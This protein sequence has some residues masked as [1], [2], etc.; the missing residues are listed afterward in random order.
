MAKRELKIERE[1]EREREM[2]VNL[3]TG[4]RHNRHYRSSAF[5]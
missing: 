4:L 1:R 2:P 5:V 3:S